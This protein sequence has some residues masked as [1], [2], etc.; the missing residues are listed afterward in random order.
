MSRRLQTAFPWKFTK[1]KKKKKK[2]IYNLQNKKKQ[3]AE[4][5]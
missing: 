2:N 3:T 4:H 5:D 1:Q